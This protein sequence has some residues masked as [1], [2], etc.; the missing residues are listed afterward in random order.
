MKMSMIDPAYLWKRTPW[1]IL[2]PTSSVP[3]WDVPME[4]GVARSGWAA[5]R[6]MT[7]SYT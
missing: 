7:S 5:A 2:I 4:N 6:E 1:E 3:S